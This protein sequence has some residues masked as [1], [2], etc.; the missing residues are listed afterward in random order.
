MQIW[1]EGSHLPLPDIVCLQFYQPTELG[2]DPSPIVVPIKKGNPINKNADVLLVDRY[3][4]YDIEFETRREPDEIPPLDSQEFLG[5]MQPKLGGL[6]PWRA[7][8]AK[9]EN[10]LG[11]ITEHP[12]GLNFG[13]TSCVLYLSR[14]N[15]IRV[16]MR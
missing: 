9:G 14:Q 10:Y 13:G 8:S 7:N 5:L 15:E 3:G 4:A 12:I 2:D 6:N 16:E 11:Q 1:V